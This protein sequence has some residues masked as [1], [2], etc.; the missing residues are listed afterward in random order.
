[1][2][3][4][5]Y[6]KSENYS[7]SNNDLLQAMNNHCNLLSYDQLDNYNDINEVLGKY[8]KCILLYLT[9]ENYGHWTC[10]YELNN[11]IY[12][13]DSY[14]FMPDQQLGFNQPYI[15]KKLNQN[16]KHLLYMLYKSNKK[17]EFNEYQLQSKKDG[18]NT[19]GRW[20]LIRLMCPQISIT[21]FYN[22]FKP[23]KNMDHKITNVTNKI[24]KY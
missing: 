9:T 18:I 11:I 1:M 17:V 24:L 12:F 4:E 13:F 20:V 21:E 3:F 14:G 7:M 10:L 2:N 16:Y 22:I 5:D 23:Y 8:K 15:N 19:C 6:R